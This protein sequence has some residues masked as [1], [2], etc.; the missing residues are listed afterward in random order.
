MKLLLMI[1]RVV[2]TLALAAS[3]QARETI[4]VLWRVKIGQ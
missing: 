1:K 2:T 4:T 3:A